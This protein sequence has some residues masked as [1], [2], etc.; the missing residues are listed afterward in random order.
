[1]F[2]SFFFPLSFPISPP[3]LLFVFF[4]LPFT[5]L[6][7][8]TAIQLLLYMWRALSLPPAYVF[9]TLFSFLCHIGVSTFMQ[10]ILSA[11]LRWK[12]S[13]VAQMPLGTAH[14]SLLLPVTR[15]TLRVE[16]HPPPQPGGTP[17]PGCGPVTD[18]PCRGVETPL[19]TPP[20]QSACRVGGASSSLAGPPCLWH[21]QA[22]LG[23]GAATTGHLR[24]SG[25]KQHQIFS[26]VLEA[27]SLKRRCQ[28]GCAASK[29]PLLPPPASGGCQHPLDSLG[30]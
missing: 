29:P 25:L 15:P 13:R 4:F 30:L 20:A 18:R 7:A 17:S 21:G 6:P 11:S 3:F 14:P 8:K 5:M 10:T 2:S 19:Q 22:V 1:M 28:Q 27:R 12:L 26:P 23:P 24:G 9:K 16:N